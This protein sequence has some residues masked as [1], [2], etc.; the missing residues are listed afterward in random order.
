MPKKRAEDESGESR[1]DDVANASIDEVC[2]C[3][4]S[5]L[6]ETLIKFNC[7]VYFVFIIF[8]TYPFCFMVSAQVV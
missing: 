6:A 8:K 1:E 5:L 2:S 7:F 3:K 4:R